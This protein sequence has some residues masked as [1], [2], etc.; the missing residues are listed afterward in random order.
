MITTKIFRYDR[1]REDLYRLLEFRYFAFV[2]E[3]HYLPSKSEFQLLQME[4]DHYDIYSE[5]IIIEK[6]NEIIACARVI[7]CNEIG[8]P[9]FDRIM[10]SLYKQLSLQNTAEVSRLIV[11]KE[12]R[13][14]FI[15]TKLL[16]TVFDS[17]L[18][19]Q[20]TYVLADTFI[21]SDS[22]N[23]LLSLGLKKAS[24]EYNDVLFS[25]EIHSIVLYFKMEEMKEKLMK[26]P[27]PRQR[28]F[29]KSYKMS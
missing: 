21:N 3:L 16:Q 18:K 9:V 28:A 10:P 20:C 13:S 19:L 26:A 11:K 14:S 7:R 17:L 29:L 15:Y 24:K 23:L 5:H 1:Q 12:Y 2:E 8:L 22:Y 25:P 27:T 6:F 4:F